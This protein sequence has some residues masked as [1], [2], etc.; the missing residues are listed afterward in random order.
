MSEGLEETYDYALLRLVSIFS[1]DLD[2][3]GFDLQG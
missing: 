3:F 1:Q 2:D